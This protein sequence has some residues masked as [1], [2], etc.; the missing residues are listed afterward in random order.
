MLPPTANGRMSQNEASQAHTGH[1]ALPNQFAAN[2]TIC[3]VW[4]TPSIRPLR[5][6]AVAGRRSR[7]RRMFS[8]AT[9]RA[10]M[11]VCDRSRSG[12]PALISKMQA[13]PKKPMRSPLYVEGGQFPASS[14][15]PPLV[16]RKTGS[17]K[18]PRLWTVH[19]AIGTSVISTAAP[20]ADRRRRTV[21]RG[22]NSTRGMTAMTS[23]ANCSARTSASTPVVAPAS[24]ARAM[25][26][27]CHRSASPSM[28]TPTITRPSGS[29]S[30]CTST[31]QNPGYAAARRA[32]TTP[33]RRPA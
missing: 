23:R 25:V 21:R 31:T 4:K 7:F 30:I 11:S 9:R 15:P 3:S 17:S 20:A 16:E 29:E 6:R 19:G 2:S 10:S 22:L 33:T 5:A 24:T 14:R 32:A 18:R 8:K 26:G 27:R 1:V 13:P 28:S 12:L